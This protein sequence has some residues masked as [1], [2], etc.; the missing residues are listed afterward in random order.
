MTPPPGYERLVRPGVE[1]VARATLAGPV[2]E[3]LAAGSLYDYAA[4]HPEARPLHG[5]GVAYAVPLPDG[6]TRV[7]VRRSRHGGWLAPLTGEIFL[8]PTRAPH[9][10][11]VSLHL[12]RE[13][14]PTP[15]VVAYSTYE[16]APLLRRA[17]VATREVPDALDLAATLDRD[18]D[19]AAVRGAVR[20]V[21][22]LLARMAVAGVRHPDLNVRNV[23]IAR[24]DNGHREAWLLD[25]DRVWFDAPRHPRVR[26]ANL[27]RFARSA[28]K[29][30]EREG[31][32]VGDGEM[33][34]LAALAREEE[35]ALP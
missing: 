25:V 11:E 30:R 27:S 29:L 3:A 4:H 32:P 26:E 5:R 19:P 34:L 9:E 33:A 20:I 18:R 15:E 12:T 22:K 31:L 21:A 13:G 7:V 24:D 8:R 6:E 16:V 14:I 1:T 35:E 10:L 2:E 28:R 23:L 17:D